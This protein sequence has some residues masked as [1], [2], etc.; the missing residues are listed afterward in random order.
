[1]YIK[2]ALLGTK[3]YRNLFKRIRD[4]ILLTAELTLP[5]CTRESC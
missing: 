3:I 5:D 4:I 1:M 2:I